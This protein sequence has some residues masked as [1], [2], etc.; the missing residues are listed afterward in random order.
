MPLFELF[1]AAR[2]KLSA[3]H[4]KPTSVSADPSFP[5]ENDHVEL[6]WESGQVVMQGQTSRAKRNPSANNS[7]SVP[8][9]SIPSHSPKRDR[10][11]SSCPQPS[12]SVKFRIPDSGLNE[13]PMSVPLGEMCLSSDDDIVPWFDYPMDESLGNDYCSGFLPEISS[14]TA[15]EP[16]QNNFDTMKRGSCSNQAYR[17]SDIKSVHDGLSLDHRTSK[18][19]S[20]ANEPSHNNFDAMKRGSCSNQPQKD[21]NINSM[22]DGLSLDHRNSSKTSSLAVTSEPIRP[23]PSHA[24]AQQTQFPSRRMRQVSENTGT[25]TNNYRVIGDSSRLTNSALGVPSKRSGKQNPGPSS[26]RT[27]FVNFS[28]FSRPAALYKS[29]VENK[30]LTVD[31]GPSSLDSAGKHNDSSPGGKTVKANCGPMREMRCHGQFL[32]EK[33]VPDSRSLEAKPS[34]KPPLKEPEGIRQKYAAK[35]DKQSNE[36]PGPSTSKEPRDAAEP[37]VASSVCSGNGVDSVSDDPPSNLKRKGCSNY[38]S[39][40]PSEDVEEDSV[41]VR[42]STPARGSGSKRSRAAE[43]HNLSERR[44]RDRI[45]E[46]MRALQELIP[47]CNKVDKASML[48]EAI[49]YLKTL[50]LQ[51]QIMSMGAGLYVPPMMLPAH[52]AQFSPMGVGMAAGLGFRMG[53]VKPHGGPPTC[54]MF[55]VPPMQG[56][57]FPSPIMSGHPALHGMVGPNFPVMG[58]PGQGIPVSMPQQPP[59]VPFPGGPPLRPYAG[60]NA[61]GMTGHMEYPDAA[62]ASSSKG[63]AETIN[64]ASSSMN[65]NLSEY[66]SKHSG[67]EQPENGAVASTTTA[68]DDNG[69]STAANEEKPV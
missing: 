5:P 37:V 1:R 31:S 7:H 34:E 48:D 24:P 26:S 57:H 22:Q 25:S 39:E 47:N 64:G 55:R 28:H 45:N 33:Q 32:V 66:Q 50:Q 17:D 16:S 54:P 56:A 63:P 52:M 35:D 21:S 43:V 3:A 10:D 42:K 2:G 20:L 44:R 23:G 41:G 29:I 61:S 27:E 58:L 68:R 4:E 8:P 53:M 38:D 46:K 11:L 40:A 67:C 69:P 65:Q 18:I 62:F 15:N 36:S 14:V 49:E 30:C 60:L 9:Y 12:S 6:V 19:S 51:V 59:S 13:L